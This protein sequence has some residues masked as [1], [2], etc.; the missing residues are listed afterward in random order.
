MRGLIDHALT[1]PQYVAPQHALSK[2]AGMLARSRNPRLKAFLIES[3][4]ALYEIDMSEAERPD[5]A[6]YASFSDF[7]TRSL[8]AECR[9]LSVDPGVLS[10]SGGRY[11][12]RVWQHRK[13]SDATGEGSPLFLIGF[14]RQR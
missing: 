9:P 3:F 2:L 1:L 13:R 10:E 7:F 5:R 8:R 6:D 12:E 11:G 14:T 4:C